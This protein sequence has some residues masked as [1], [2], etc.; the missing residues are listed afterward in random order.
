[1][2]EEDPYSYLKHILRNVDDFVWDFYFQ[3]IQFR[4]SAAKHFSF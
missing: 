4:R 1:M 3:L 2:T